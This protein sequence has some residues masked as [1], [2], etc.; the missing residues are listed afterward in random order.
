MNILGLGLMPPTFPRRRN[1]RALLGS[2]SRASSLLREWRMRHRNS[3]PGRT[4]RREEAAIGARHR[5]FRGVLWKDIGWVR[6]GGPQLVSRRRRQSRRPDEGLGSLLTITPIRW[7]WRRSCSRLTSTRCRPTRPRAFLFCL[8]RAGA[9]KRRIFARSTCQSPGVRRRGLPSVTAGRGAKHTITIV[10]NDKGS[11]AK[12]RHAELLFTAAGRLEARRLRHRSA[13]RWRAQRDV[14]ARRSRSTAS[15]ELRVRPQT[16][17]TAQNKLRELIPQ[18]RRGTVP[19]SRRPRRPDLLR[20]PTAPPAGTWRFLLPLRGSAHSRD[21]LS[22][23][24]RKNG[25]SCRRRHAQG[26]TGSAE[27]SRKM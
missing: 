22:N 3:A 4:L 23:S 26:R 6:A 13:G 9:L 21:R 7:R 18:A 10:A 24:A 20:R 1:L 19:T 25:S 5:A 17:S 15:A 8:V 11:P 14:P 16:D 2:V 12:A 27:R